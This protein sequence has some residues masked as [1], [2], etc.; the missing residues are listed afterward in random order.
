MLR[1]AG[2]AWACGL[3]LSAQAVPLP[4]RDE[5]TVRRWG[6]EDG[7]PEGMITSIQPFP[8]G[9]LWLTTP[10]HVVR[11]DGVRFESVVADAFPSNRPTAFAGLYRDRVEDVWVYG[12]GGA[13]RCHAGTWETVAFDGPAVPETVFWA[14]ETTERTLWLATDNGLW[15]FDGKKMIHYPVVLLDREAPKRIRSAA[16]DGRGTIWLATDD[17]LL[18][19]QDGVYRVQPFPQGAGPGN[20]DTIVVDGRDAVWVH[21]LSRLR[22]IPHQQPAGEWQNR[23]CKNHKPQGRDVPSGQSLAGQESDADEKRPNRR[24]ALRRPAEI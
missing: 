24:N 22:G 16:M 15:R 7:L 9:F 3:S 2:A 8:D 20:I 12:D 5:Y 13:M 23:L 17:L 1:S 6:V 4:I 10:R 21:S 14:G 11:F 19:F 18:R